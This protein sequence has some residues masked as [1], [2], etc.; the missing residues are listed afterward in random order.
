[1][2][3]SRYGETTDMLTYQD[4]ATGTYPDG[5]P[6]QYSVRCFEQFKNLPCWLTDLEVG[7][8]IGPQL[9]PPQ[10][11]SDLILVSLAVFVSERRR[12]RRSM[13]LG[14]NEVAGL[15]RIAAGDVLYGS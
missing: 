13:P 15:L 12:S 7:Y 5:T 14:S 6:E 9:I 10:T 2:R 8:R 1:M 4:W 11:V 3:Q